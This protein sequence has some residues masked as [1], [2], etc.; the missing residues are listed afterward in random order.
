MGLFRG[1]KFGLIRIPYAHNC[2]IC[3][4]YN[5]GGGV[6]IEIQAER[7]KKI[8][9]K[10]GDNIRKRKDGR[11]EGRYKKGRT[12]DGSLIYGSVYGKTYKETKAKME[13]VAKNPVPNSIP[14]NKEKTFGEVLNLWMSHNRVRLKGGTINKYQSLIDT[15]IMPELGSIRIT[16]LSATQINAFLDKKLTNGRIDGS[17]GLSPSYVRSIM[18][19]ISAAVKYAVDE[20]LC[21]PLKSNVCKP[22]TTKTDLLILS[23]EE[24]RKLETVLLN[25]FDMTCAGI[26][27]SLHTGLRIGEI[28]GLAWD[29]IDFD[30]M[31]IHV[32]HTVARIKTD[33]HTTLILDTPK[34]K[35]SK[36]D[37]PISSILFPVL[38]KLRSFSD[39]GFVI[40]G[41]NEFM[42]PRTFEYRYHR[43]LEVTGLDLVN[44]HALRHTFATRCVEVGVDVKSLSEILGHGNVSITLNTYVH[45]SMEMKRNQLEKLTTLSA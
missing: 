21:L 36:R 6:L 4:F 32:R 15:H 42:K 20:Q 9:A 10:R 22:A 37:I 29:D 40:T 25:K 19:V 39:R 16:D 31:V 1:Q 14:K 13:S 43:I 33:E 30:A 34:T 3:V 18:L 11:W 38:Q 8:M 24:Q 45:S 26:F 17:G 44:Y 2:E 28:C 41:T 5:W 35:A 12:A 23:L 7:S 27:I